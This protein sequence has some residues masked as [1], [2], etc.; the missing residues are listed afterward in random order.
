MALLGLRWMSWC[1][2]TPAA[3]SS[4][5]L[6]AWMSESQ[7]S[8]LVQNNLRFR[9]TDIKT[10]KCQWYRHTLS[11]SGAI[12]D[13][14]NTYE[15][16]KVAF[17]FTILYFALYNNHKNQARPARKADHVLCVGPC[18]PW[19]VRVS[20]GWSILPL[21]G[22]CGLIKNILFNSIPIQVNSE[23]LKLT[24]FPLQSYQYARWM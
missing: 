15:A 24:D 3:S 14:W 4:S 17:Q 23:F 6:D 5:P 9:Q 10:M 11:F 2:C 12:A 21:F 7:W 1:R 8:T 16:Q 13:S 20:L 18:A 19:R 22:Q